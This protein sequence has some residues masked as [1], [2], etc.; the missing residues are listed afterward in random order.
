MNISISN[1]AWDLDEDEAVAEV[2]RDQGI[3]GVE[4]AP[5]KIWPQPLAASDREIEAYRAFWE[6]RGIRIVAMQSLLFGRSD[7]TIFQSAE[8]T[9]E[10]LNYLKGIIRL[11]NKLGAHALVFGSPKNRRVETLSQAEIDRIALPFFQR[12]GETAMQNELAFCIEPNAPLYECDYVQTSREGLDLVRSVGSEGF[13]LHLDAAAMT[14]CGEEIEEALS[15]SLPLMSHFH[16]SEPHLSPIGSGVVDHFLFAT[17]LRKLDYSKWVSIEMR[18]TAKA[19]HLESVR[20]ALEFVR[21]LYP[22]NETT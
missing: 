10:T 20:S 2:L 15:D 8:K 18:A 16:V 19:T 12:I 5:S 13:R 4:I 17:I 22:A 3:S 9:R 1:I 6:S 7:L 14:L 11:G 21:R